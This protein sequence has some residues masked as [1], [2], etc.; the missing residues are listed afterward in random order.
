MSALRGMFSRWALSF[1]TAM[2]EEPVIV[3]SV[4]AGLPC[5]FLLSRSAP[6][7]KVAGDYVPYTLIDAATEARLRFNE[8][9]RFTELRET[10]D[11]AGAQQDS[12]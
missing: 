4:I 11:E 6:V 12:K 3:Y 8:P 10:S 5:V 7:R 1:K 9:G 2:Q